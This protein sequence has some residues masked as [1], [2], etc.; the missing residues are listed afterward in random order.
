[1]SST[2]KYALAFV[3][4][5][6]TG[7]SP[8]KHDPWEIAVILREPDAAMAPAS[9]TEHVF[10]VRPDLTNAD[11]KGLEINRYYE[12]TGADDWTW[13]DPKEVAVQLRDLLDRTVLVGSNPSFDAGMISGFIGRHHPGPYV[14]TTPW[15]HHTVDIATLAAG[16]RFGQAASGRYG[17]DFTFA[18]DYPQLPYRSYD[19]SRAVGIEPPAK[20]VAHTALG[21]AAWA[22]DVYDAVTGGKVGGA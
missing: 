4:T 11:P 18:T 22:R 3:D 20:D 17:G 19:M 5:E 16:Y 7:L 10:R 12:R 2:S 1:M 6:T 9:D 8:F 13:Q 14:N 21:D 15:Y